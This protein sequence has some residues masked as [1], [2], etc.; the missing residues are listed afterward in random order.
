MMIPMDTFFEDWMEILEKPNI[1]PESAM[2]THCGNGTQ[3][4]CS[5]GHGNAVI[6]NWPYIC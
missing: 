4:L 6:V 1:D 5:P 2:R 3:F